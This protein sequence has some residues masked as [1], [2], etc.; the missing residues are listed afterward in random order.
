MKWDKLGVV[1]APD[2]HYDW[3]KTHAANPVAEHRG[4]DYFRVYFGCR[5][6]QNRSSVG[7]VDIDLT[8]TAK[9]VDVAKQPV[10]APGDL[11][12]FDD[13]GTSMGCLVARGTKR[14]LYYLGW[15][16]GVTVPW[17]NSIGLA[18]SN[19]PGEPFVKYSRAPIVDRCEVDPFS[20]SYP[21]VLR[22]GERMKMWYGSNLRWY[23]SNLSWGHEQ[24]DMAYVLKYAESSDGIHWERDGV[25]AM[26]LKT[27]AESAICRPCV[28]KEEEGYRMWYSYRGEKYR[29]GYAES[30]DG[31]VWDRKDEH[32]GIAPSASGWD[33]EMIEY[34]FVFVHAGTR[35]MLYNGNGYGATGIGLAILENGV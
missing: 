12:S 18:V 6:A 2:N 33:S 28:V 29:I 21:W 24:G 14:Y 25:I 35:Y 34:P 32:V 11:G 23:G 20:V 17:R 31:L 7:F 5:D 16:L 3:M 30:S 8:D 13:S 15:N 19:A 26:D 4:G 22:D 1:F 9:V 27:P 10:I